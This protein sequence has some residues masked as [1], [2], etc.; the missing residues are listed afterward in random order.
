MNGMINRIVE[1]SVRN[2]IINEEDIEI[3]KY[4]LES[5]FLHMISTTLLILLGIFLRRIDIAIIYLMVLILLRKNTGGYHCKTFLACVF[6]TSIGLLFIIITNNI[7]GEYWKELIGILFILY[8]M[9][10]IYMSDPILN[11]NRM[12]SDTVVEKCKKTKNKW[13][14]ILVCISLIFHFLVKLQLLNS[15]DYFYAITSSLMIVAL[16]INNLRREN[17]EKT[18]KD[19]IGVH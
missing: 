4:G 10:K 12:V 14:L 3:T 17:H 5:I 19:G 6:T 8:S 9:I 15:Y 18:N 1:I 7:I 11:K 16:S 13:L 2:R